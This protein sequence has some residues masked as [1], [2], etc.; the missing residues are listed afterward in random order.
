[1]L[2]EQLAAHALHTRYDRFPADVVEAARLRLID[3][4]SCTLG[5]MHGSGIAGMRELVLEWGGKPQAT[6]LAFGDRVPLHQAA[7]LNSL[8]TRSFD[9]EVCGPEPEGINAG[10]MVGHVSSTTEPTALAVAEFM[11]A[12]GQDLLSAVILGGDI[13]ARIAVADEFNFDRCFEVCGT[14][15]AFGAAAL[16][17]RLMGLDPAQMV[18]AFGILLHLLGGS[19]QSLWD[20]VDSFKLPGAMA[21]SHGVMAV[22]M[23]LKG[24]SG[25][26]DALE[27]PQGYFALFGNKPQPSNALA[28]LGQVF[29]AKGQHKLHPSCYGNHNPIDSA[30]EIVSQHRFDP[31][32]I[33]LVTL[34]VPPHRVRHFLNQPMDAGDAQ[35]RSLFS[36]PYGVANVLVRREVR[37]EHYTE[38]CIRDPQVLALTHKVRL[39]PSLSSGKNHAGRLVVK[40][41]DGRELSAYREAPR[42]WL[43]NPIGAEDIHRKYWRNVEFCGAIPREQAQ[44]AL[45]MLG[46]L[47]TLPDVRLL[48]AQLSRA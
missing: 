10:K 46:R 43:D 8:M 41:R 25:V 44:A 26:R 24:F 42:G 11:G 18:N 15:N 34:E 4:L 9:F 12:S 7:W 48:V 19:F 5:G 28:D 1:M 33:E 23:A 6:V 27:S 47:E 13:A 2:I 37:L 16:T 29:Y 21:A 45:D 38:P 36:I 32:D 31:Q 20:G 17:G 30:Q 3:A 35:P 14:A 40:L 22:Q 39:E